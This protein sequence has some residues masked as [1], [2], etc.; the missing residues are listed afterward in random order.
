MS[1]A[2]IL[3]VGV[4]VSPVPIAAVTLILSGSRSRAVGTSFAFGWFFGVSASI[5]VFIAVVGAADAS[6][7]SPLW[8]AV[9][10]LALG[11]AFLALAIHIWRGRRREANDGPPAWLGALDRLTP[12]RS[13]ALGLVLSAANPKNLA[14]ALGAAIA[15]AE[16]DVGSALTARTAALF[17]LIGTAG[18]AVPVAISIVAPKRTDSVLGRFR[19]WLVRYDSVI[20]TIL[21]VTV[22]AKFVFDGLTDL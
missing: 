3:A 7:E 12:P 13:A 15:L 9:L 4:A 14:L 19:T 1:D 5:L 2:L 17:I 22:G 18:V 6:D 10:E 21:G 16:A 11:I 8:I 20:L